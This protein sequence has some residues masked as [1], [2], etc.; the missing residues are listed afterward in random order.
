MIPPWILIGLSL[1]DQTQIHQESPRQL[2][3]NRCFGLVYL[4]RGF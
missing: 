1:A 2:I 4:L 3:P